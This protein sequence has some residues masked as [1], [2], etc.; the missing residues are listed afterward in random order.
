MNLDS[1]DYLVLEELSEKSHMK[2]SFF[3]FYVYT[4]LISSQTVK[5]TN[6]WK[7]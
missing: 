3:D 1:L 7:H 5:E 6:E 2:F 4:S